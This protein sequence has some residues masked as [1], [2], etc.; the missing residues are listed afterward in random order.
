MKIGQLDQIVK[1]QQPTETNTSG[2]V[3]KSYADVATVWARIVSEKGNEA[4]TSARV[5]AREKLRIEIRHRSDVD[6]TWRLVWDAKNYNILN[7]DR[8]LRR[9]G[10]LWLT[11]E[12]V[13]AV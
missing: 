12:L 4:F 3:V 8:S 11:C 5:N 9:K 6:V 2:S 7:V 1:L 13:G 10:E